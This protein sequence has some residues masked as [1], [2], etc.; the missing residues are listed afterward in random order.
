MNEIHNNDTPE[1]K[2][3]EISSYREIKPE[4]GMAVNEAKDFWNTTFEQMEHDGFYTS[5]SDR[6]DCTPA[7]NPDRG[8]WEGERGNGKFIPNEASPEGKAAKEK[9]AK[10][11]MNG[12]EFQNA[13]PDFSKCSEATVSID[14]MT[15]HRFDHIDANGEYRSGNFSQADMKCAEQWNETQKDGK[16]DW[17]PR[18]V[19][20]WRHENECTWH[21]RPDCKTMDLVPREIHGFFGHSG[22]CAECKARDAVND[23]G[24]FDE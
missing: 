6:F 20:N 2:N 17:T 8:F 4:T 22:G 12:I 24:D 1:M 13:V 7:D 10:F 16:T 23:G 9:L 19:K 15:E 5:F 21:E 14:N 18:D 3:Q 11:D